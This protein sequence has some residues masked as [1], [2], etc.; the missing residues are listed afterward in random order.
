MIGTNIREEAQ[1]RIDL[2]KNDYDIIAV[3]TKENNTIL[4]DMEET[5][6]AI[7]ILT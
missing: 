3:I 1:R 4:N 6:A 7:I 5:I 2:A